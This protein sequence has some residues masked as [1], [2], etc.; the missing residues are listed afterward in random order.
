MNRI[1]AF[2]DRFILPHPWMVLVL[3]GAILALAA[4]RFDQFRLDASAE[5][6]VLENDRSLEEYRQVNR[7]FTTSDDF[8]VVTYTP[9]EPLFT[10]EGLGRL[11]A[12][13]DELQA[14]EAVSSTNS[15]LNVPLLHSPDLTLDTVDTEIKTLDEHEVAPD[16][17]RQALLDNPMYP[18]LLLS[19]DAGTTAIQVNLPTPERYFELLNQRD[20]LRDRVNS[21]NASANDQRQLEQVS[22]EF[23]RYT[24]SLGKERDATIRKVRVILDN[25]REHASIHLGGVPMIVA[26]MIRFIKSDLSTFGLGVLAF[27]LLTLAVI[28]RQWRWVLV[29]LLCCGFT[30]WLMIGFLGWA[31]WPV[32]VISSNFISLLLIMTLSLTIHLIVRYREFQH[33]EPGAAPRDVLRRTVMAMIKPCFYMAITTIVAFGSLTFSGIRPVIDFGWMMTLGLSVAFII[34]FLVFPALLSLLPPPLD[35]RVTSDRIPFT[36][37]FARFTERFGGTVLVGSGVIAA[38]CV[39]GLNRLTVENSFI[40]YFKSS[41]EI[42]QGMITIDDRLGGTTPLDVVITDEPPPENYSDD[43]FASDCD[44]FVEDCDEE[45]YRDTWYTYQKMRQLGDVHDYLNS[46]PETGKVLSISTTLDL[47]A[48]INGGTPLNAVELAFVP[49]AVPDDLQ[50]ILLTPYI[51][52]EQS[53]AR[54]SIRILETM[55]DLRRQDLLD[56]IHNHLT[57]DLGYAPERVQLSGM[58]VMYN[59]MLQ[60]LFDSQIKTIGVVFAAIMV[61]F[62][63]LFRS[64]KLALIGMAPNLIAAG[65]VLGLM[66]WLGIPLDMMTITVAAITVGIAVDDT[67]HYIHRF[68]TEL[69]KDGD[70]V[71]TMHRCHRSIGQAMFFTSLTIISG[72][73]ILVLSNFIPTIYFGL[74]TGFAM[75][76]ALVGALTLLPR[77]IILFKP[78]PAR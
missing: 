18:N 55:P 38:L 77:L 47:L 14:L 78:F 64:L 53:Q 44:P 15:I 67:I 66:G 24:E 5:S 28:F 34:T 17:A 21:G 65:S 54:F 69:A 8:L 71:A 25:H 46:L 41:T 68:K 48:Q 26:D 52:E 40:D 62:L 23:I 56:R 45:D 19:E 57:T 7:T 35:S 4:V 51:S 73:S 36:D 49:A 29:P 2:Y 63:I 32:T 13:R 43:P 42:H 22:Q 16:T 27:L 39:V 76:M 60:S 31:Q 37:A 75:F 30:V 33:D 50:D 12:L 6:L 59:N 9:H 3:F 20:N 1:G 61:M 11:K 72:F 10:P 58:T 70:Y 74:F